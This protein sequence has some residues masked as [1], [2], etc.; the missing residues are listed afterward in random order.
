M[1]SHLSGLLVLVF[2]AFC[3]WA[4]CFFGHSSAISENGAALSLDD[5]VATIVPPLRWRW[6]YGSHEMNALKLAG[7]DQAWA[8][9]ADGVILHSSDG[10]R[11]WL[12]QESGVGNALKDVFFVD[13]TTGWVV[14]EK[15]VILHTV[16]GG[17]SWEVQAS[18]TGANLRT[19]WFIDSQTGWVGLPD[20]VL[21]TIDGGETWAKAGSL[22][23]EVK[24]LQFFDADTGL[25]ICNSGSPGA[26]RIMRTSDGG[27]TWTPATCQYVGPGPSSGPCED[28]FTALHFPTRNFGCAVGG[29]VGPLAYTTD[30][31]GASWTEQETNIDFAEPESVFF[32]DTN[33]GWATGYRGTLLT[34]DGGRTWS[35]VESNDSGRDIVFMSPDE[36]LVT[37]W[38]GIERSTDGGLTW[39]LAEPFAEGSVEGI[40]FINSREGWAVGQRWSPSG[41]RIVHTA[42][43]GQTWQTQFETNAYLNA[44]HFVNAL[45]G[46]AVGDTGV[47]AATSN[48]G[49]TWSYQ[50]AATDFDLNDIHFVDANYG[51]IVGDNGY[52]GRVWRTTDGGKHWTQS[53]YFTGKWSNGKY[54][55]QFV[56]RTLGYIA[57]EK[58][59]GSDDKHGSVWST[60]NGGDTWVEK[61][62]S[63]QYGALLSLAFVNANVGWAVGEDGIIARTTNGG[64]SWELQASGVGYDLHDVV[65]L[66]AQKGYV[67]GNTRTVR[68]TTDGGQTWGEEKVTNSTNTTINYYSVAFPDSYQAWIGGYYGISSY[69]DPTAPPPTP[70]PVLEEHVYVPIILR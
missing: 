14:G 41:G 33:K 59:E 35:M 13:D 2:W 12:H 66:D 8:V 55:V 21:K 27:T 25:L 34:S 45:R 60:T 22:P 19:A 62:L 20:G 30:D 53:G 9:G 65:F 43:G 67:V 16:N 47:I 46:W 36:G 58:A 3:L 10:G 57:G 54:T 15:G 64:D 51:W 32:L 68:K 31:G 7:A 49:G 18:N 4:V 1:K 44:V 48:G 61:P 39:S 29:W 38:V 50:T 28:N 52:D 26:G 63:G 23:S 70:V 6:R 11:S 42:D 5:S 24:S 17:S 37:E 40:S 69:T 56:S